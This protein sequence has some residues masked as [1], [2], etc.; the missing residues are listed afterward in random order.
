MEQ[1]TL[2]DGTLLLC[3]GLEEKHI[4]V[5]ISEIEPTESKKS[6]GQR[7]D[8]K[9]ASKDQQR[10]WRRPCIPSIFHEHASI[11]S[12][13]WHSSARFYCWPS[14]ADSTCDCALCCSTWPRTNLGVLFLQSILVRLALLLLPFL[15]Y[16]SLLDTY[17]TLWELRTKLWMLP[18]QAGRNPWM[19]Y[20]WSLAQSEGNG[21]SYA[22]GATALW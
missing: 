6:G 18:D 19:Q 3:R 20:L 5:A 11:Y 4:A 12:R 9:N 7:L 16:V 15:E 2:Y 8:S 10:L 14:R 1:K 21:T 13:G 17:Q 22:S